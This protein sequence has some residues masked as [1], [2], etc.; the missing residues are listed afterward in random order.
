MIIDPELR[1][2]DIESV[3]LGIE[4]LEQ[5]V[6]LIVQQEPL[7]L[8]I[9]APLD[10]LTELGTHEVELGARMADLIEHHGTERSEL[11]PDIAR[12]L[13]YQ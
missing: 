8:L 1:M 11:A 7:E 2:L 5:S 13:V 10:E 6:R 12:H 4:A 9:E 3:Q